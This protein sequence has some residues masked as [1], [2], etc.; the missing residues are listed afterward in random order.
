MTL[1][2]LT[3]A[4]Y[5]QR[6]KSIADLLANIDNPIPEKTLVA[7]LLNGLSSQ[8]EH[9]A[10]LLRHRDPLPTFLQ[11]RSKLLVEEQRFKNSRPLQAS[12]SDHSS[13]HSVLLTGNNTRNNSGSSQSS[14]Q[15]RQFQQRR[16]GRATSQQCLQ[17]PAG[18]SAASQH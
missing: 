6:I 7:H 16:G 17:P 10:T 15:R 3:I 4:Q 9:I 1:G 11:A 13:S 2:D 8:Y 18:S 14:T 5:C 12:H